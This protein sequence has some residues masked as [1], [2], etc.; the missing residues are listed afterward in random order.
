MMFKPLY[1]APVGQPMTSIFNRKQEGKVSRLAATHQLVATNVKSQL[2][3]APL[4]V[5]VEHD[6]A[7]T[8]RTEVVANVQA[9]ASGPQMSDKILWLYGKWT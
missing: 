9:S 7:D 5:T 8:A 4:T 6:D 1:A 2:G 3:C